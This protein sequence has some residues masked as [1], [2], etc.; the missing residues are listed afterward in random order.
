MNA[1]AEPDEDNYYSSV[2][3]MTDAA[4]E[5]ASGR[6]ATPNN[7]HNNNNNNI[8]I[9]KPADDTP[10][11]ADSAAGHTKNKFLQKFRRRKKPAQNIENIPFIKLV[12]PT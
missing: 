7:N 1:E 5:R 6:M 2:M 11:V 9:S 10:A 12:R 3:E 8:V 4:G